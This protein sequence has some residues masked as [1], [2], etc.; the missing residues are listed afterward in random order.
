MLSLWIICVLFAVIS[1]VNTKLVDTETTQID[2][3]S[4][5]GTPL[6]QV[7]VIGDSL[8]TK[9]DTHHALLKRMHNLAAKSIKNY[10]LKFSHGKINGNMG[11]INDLV[12]G[13]FDCIRLLLFCLISS[14]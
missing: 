8:V 1:G 4:N 5:E 7:I 14:M 2:D 10:K 6:I 3:I 9:S 13:N 11:K 12:Q